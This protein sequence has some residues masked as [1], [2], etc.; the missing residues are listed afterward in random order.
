[1]TSIFLVRIADGSPPENEVGANNVWQ[2]PG[3]LP[4]GN[5]EIVADVGGMEK[6][7]D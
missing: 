4:E 7:T 3:M 1:M 2:P 6:C 5:A